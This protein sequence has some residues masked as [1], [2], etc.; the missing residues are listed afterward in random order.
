[1]EAEGRNKVDTRPGLPASRGFADH[2]GCSS[3]RK[4]RLRV[5]KSYQEKHGLVTFEK[6]IA[7]GIFD[8]LWP[9][10]DTLVNCEKPKLF[11][12]RIRRPE[13]IDRGAK[14]FRT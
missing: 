13:R 10:S 4:K 9:S 3:E 5:I 6:V 12:E 14:G 8:Q 7:D 11:L 1:M 2:G